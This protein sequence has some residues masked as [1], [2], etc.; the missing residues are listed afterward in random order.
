MAGHYPRCEGANLGVS[1]LCHFDLLWM[2]LAE[3][4]CFQRENLLSPA[5]KSASSA[6]NSVRTQIKGK[7]G[8]G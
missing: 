8:A 4:H 7:K 3:E 6:R 1:D 5:P 2:E